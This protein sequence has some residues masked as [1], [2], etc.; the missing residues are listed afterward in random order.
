VPE[1]MMADT[2]DELKKQAALAH[3]QGDLEGARKLL[4]RAHFIAGQID[5]N[6][7]VRMPGA[8]NSLGDPMLAAQSMGIDPSLVMPQQGAAAGGAAEGE[9]VPG[10][11]VSPEMQVGPDGAPGVQGNSMPQYQRPTGTQ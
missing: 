7:M 4:H 3:S 8:M 5:F 1:V 11:P 10:T 2:L 6:Q 9:E